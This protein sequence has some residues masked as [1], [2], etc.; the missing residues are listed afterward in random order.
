[1]HRWDTTVGAATIVWIV[2][3]ATGFMAF[4]ADLLGMEP[5][6]HLPEDVELGWDAANWAIWA[7]FV[8]DVYGKYRKSESPR[9][10]LRCNW[11]D[12][13]FL[14]PFF[15]ILLILRV[16]RLLRLVRIMRVAGAASEALE[17]HFFTV[18]KILGVGRLRRLLSRIHDGS[19][20]AKKSKRPDRG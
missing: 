20:G 5:L 1:M 2:M 10:F 11:L 4:D 14:I 8:A 13:L 17:I 16:V 3:F 9:A 15:R 18:Q 19:G 12:L 7:V 6:I